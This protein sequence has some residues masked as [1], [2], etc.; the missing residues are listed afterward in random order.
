MGKPLSH[1]CIRLRNAAL[2][3]LFE[4]VPLH[5][6]VIIDE[7]PQPQWQIAALV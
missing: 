5:C 3:E 6:S 7:A 4:R 1:G 2:I